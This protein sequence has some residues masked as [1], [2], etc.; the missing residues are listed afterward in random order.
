[1]NPTD[2][3]ENSLRALARKPLP[4]APADLSRGVWAEIERRRRQSFWSRVFPLLEWREMFREP[5]LAVAA[6]ACALA[7]GILPAAAWNRTQQQHRLAQQSLHLDVFSR[8]PTE[9]LAA[10]FATPT[11]M[12]RP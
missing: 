1:M 8:A 12:T 11:G 10:L 6:L 5:R 7:I 3:L 9:R 4:G 2:P